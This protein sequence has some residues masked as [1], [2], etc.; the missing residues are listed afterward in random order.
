MTTIFWE[1][2]MEALEVSLILIYYG[3]TSIA[4]LLVSITSWSSNIEYR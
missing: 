4:K 1:V 3:E 2:L